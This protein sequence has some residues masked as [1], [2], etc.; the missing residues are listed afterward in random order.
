MQEQ[1]K[2]DHLLEMFNHKG[3]AEF[4]KEIVATLEAAEQ[5]AV[6]DCQENDQWQFRRGEIF[7]LKQIAGYENFIKTVVD[8][9]EEENAEV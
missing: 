7:K 1:E 2:Y 4:Q 3:W 8:Q 6:D 9:M 5:S